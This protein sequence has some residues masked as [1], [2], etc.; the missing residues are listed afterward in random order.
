MFTRFALALCAV[1][2]LQPLAWAESPAA[3]E[4]YTLAHEDAFG[5][6]SLGKFDFTDS[7]AWGLE[8]AEGNTLLALKRPSKYAPPVRSPLNIAW[9]KDF[10]AGDFVLDVKAKQTGK[11]YNHRDL[12]IFFGGQSEQRFYYVHLA[13]VADAN[14]NSIFLVNDAP[15]TG[16]AEKRTD[17][18]KWT[19]AFHNIRIK[20]D[21]QAGYIE[22]YFDDMETPVMTAVNRQFGEGKIGLGSFDD[23]GLFDDLKIY[24]KTPKAGE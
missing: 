13:S 7:K 8:D 4:G 1:A 2:V 21:A 14:A 11:E 17:G 6:G 5:E 18:T 10:K 19:D 24:T 12:C 22:V 3:P 23:V 20:R 16:I 9:I 15:R